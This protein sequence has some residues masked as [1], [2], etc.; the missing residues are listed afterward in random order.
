MRGDRKYGLF[1]MM[2]RVGGQ[3]PSLFV[4]NVQVHRGPAT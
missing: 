4:V 2:Y 3:A 1:S